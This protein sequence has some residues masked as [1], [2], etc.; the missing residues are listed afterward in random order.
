M[1]SA[2][3]VRCTWPQLPRPLCLP[4]HVQVNKLGAS[5]GLQTDDVT[6]RGCSGLRADVHRVIVWNRDCLISIV[7]SVT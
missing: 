3:S 2:G 7:L 5:D 6:L 1:M 4:L